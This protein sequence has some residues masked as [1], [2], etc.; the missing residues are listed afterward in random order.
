MSL[1]SFYHDKVVI[2][3]GGSMGIGKELAKRLLL[4]GAKVLISG[5]TLSK[6][7]AVRQEFNASVDELQLFAGD[8]RSEESNLEMVNLCLQKFGRLD[9]LINNAGMSAV[10]ELAEMRASVFKQVVDINIYGSTYPTMAAI[11]ALKASKGSILFVSSIAGMTGLPAYSAYSMSKMSLRSLAHALRIELSR[12]GVFVGICYVGFTENEAGKRTLN[13]QGV[14]EAIPSRPAALTASRE[15]TAKRM[16]RQI[17]RRKFSVNQS[18]LG[19]TVMLLS[20]V[21]PG[22]TLLIM[23]A[24]YK[25]PHS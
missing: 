6:L 8:V 13:K 21:F 23:K 16:L 10:G 14:E 19:K 18:I 12:Y 3:T 17:K 2:V 15:K 9:I 24:N 7:E 22:L 1:G 25:P 4:Y 11:N 5:R 20:R